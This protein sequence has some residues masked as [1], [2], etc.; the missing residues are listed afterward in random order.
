M[1]QPVRKVI[2]EITSRAKNCVKGKKNGINKTK[3][4]RGE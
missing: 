1:G 2:E 4:V 3:K